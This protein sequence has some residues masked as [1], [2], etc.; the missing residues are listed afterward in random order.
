MKVSQKLEISDIQLASI[1]QSTEMAIVHNRQLL[2]DENLPFREFYEKRLESITELFVYLK[3]EYLKKED[4]FSFKLEQIL[5]LPENNPPSVSRD[6]EVIVDSA[7]K[8]EEE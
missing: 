8:Y 2:E 5:R 4:Q 3:G 6:A 7:P 1:I